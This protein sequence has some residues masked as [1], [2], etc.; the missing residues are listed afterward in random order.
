MV[1]FVAAR[2]T[3][4]SIIGGL[5][6]LAGAAIGVF[7]TRRHYESAEHKKLMRAK[8]EEL[9]GLVTSILLHMNY[10]ARSGTTMEHAVKT[11]SLLYRLELMKSLY[12][13]EIKEIDALHGSTYELHQFM[14]N[15]NWAPDLSRIS[16]SQRNRLTHIIGEVS[17]AARAL[18]DELGK[19]ARNL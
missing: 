4:S 8:V 17:G 12:F 14:F 2:E 10:T 1:K 7:F 5:F 6:T 19:R 15:L 13:D 16:P 18:L 3:L 11:S 9:G